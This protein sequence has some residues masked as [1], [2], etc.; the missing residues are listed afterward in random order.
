MA[1]S[2][3]TLPP[4]QRNDKAIV[5]MAMG[6]P[7]TGAMPPC[8]NQTQLTILVQEAIDVSLPKTQIRTFAQL[9]EVQHS[10]DVLRDVYIHSRL[11]K[12][13]GWFQCAICHK[14]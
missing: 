14:H 8:C 12:L 10:H 6:A 7:F 9:P 4:R 13:R 5:K 2:L 1:C 3:I 11:E